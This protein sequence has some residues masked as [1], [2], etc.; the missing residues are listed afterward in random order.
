[1]KTLPKKD[2]NEREVSKLSDMEFKIMIIRILK[3]LTDNY[4]ELREN[5]N[6]MEKEIESINKN[7]EELNN[8]I[9]ERKKKHTTKNYKQPG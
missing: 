8:K 9:L 5:Y 6:S 3:K 4:K 1:M 7:Q 2:L